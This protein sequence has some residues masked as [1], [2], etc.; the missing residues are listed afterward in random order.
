MSANDLLRDLRQCADALRNPL[1]DCR[2]FSRAR[3]A[4]L[5]EEAA[6]IIERLRK[7]LAEA[8]AACSEA[9]SYLDGEHP[10]WADD[11]Q[12]LWDTLDNVLEDGKP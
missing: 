11:N 7:E 2:P 10:D 3:Q 8:S 5:M 6:A 1:C 4:E 12:H 9:R